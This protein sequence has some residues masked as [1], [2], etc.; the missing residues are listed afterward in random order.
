MKKIVI[1]KVMAI[2]ANCYGADF[3]KVLG[4]R[5]KGPVDNIADFNIW[6]SP[7]LFNNQFKNDVF[8]AKYIIKQS[9]DVQ[10]EKYHFFKNIFSFPNGMNIVHND[11]RQLKYRM[12]LKKRIRKFHRYYKK[13]LTRNDLW[14]I[15]SLDYSDSSLSENRVMQLRNQLPA[16][17]ADRLIVLGIRAHNE[18]FKKYFKYYV[19][20]DNEEIYRWGDK[21]QGIEIANL[22]E[23]KYQ[24]RINYE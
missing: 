3:T 6:K 19:E 18:L 9:S 17:C 16:V 7:T 4:V 2:G 21:T 12:S 8:K 10:I 11:F 23:K 22:L 1:K 5:E 13:S 14:Y 24:V 20:L 15:Y